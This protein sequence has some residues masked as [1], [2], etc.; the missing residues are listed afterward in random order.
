[1]LPGIRLRAL[2]KSIQEPVKIDIPVASPAAV[3]VTDPCTVVPIG[4]LVT[5]GGPPV[6]D[7]G[8]VVEA[9]AVTAV[10]ARASERLYVASPA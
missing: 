9:M 2:C 10:L 8:V 3:T 5:T 7:R 6:V 4:T 1:M